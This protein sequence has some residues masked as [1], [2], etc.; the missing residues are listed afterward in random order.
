[1]QLTFC[2]DHLGNVNIANDITKYMFSIFQTLFP[3]LVVKYNEYSERGSTTL[4]L[5]H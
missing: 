1:M 5:S 3:F 4:Q 2:L